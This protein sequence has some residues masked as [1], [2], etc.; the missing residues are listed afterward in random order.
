VT[1]YVAQIKH[2]VSALGS[3]DRGIVSVAFDERVGSPPTASEDALVKIQRAQN[4]KSRPGMTTY[5]QVS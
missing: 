1:V 3:Y 4:E 5:S 2:R